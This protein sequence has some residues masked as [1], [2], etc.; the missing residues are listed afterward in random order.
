MVYE[1]ES[2][3][4]SGSWI[5]SKPNYDPRIESDQVETN[6]VRFEWDWYKY[7][8]FGSVSGKILTI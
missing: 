7:F 6:F 5:L 4:R 1:L 3:I 8:E 2:D